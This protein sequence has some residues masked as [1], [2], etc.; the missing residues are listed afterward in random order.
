MASG[1]FTRALA[2]GWER[3]VAD[4]LLR[5]DIAACVDGDPE[6]RL[7]GP[8]AL[9]ERLR[10]LPERRGRV[11]GRARRKKFVRGAIA[12]AALRQ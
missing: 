7:A 11:E 10:S 5:E 8:A 9:A 1:D 12:A 4:P 3:H 2:P 6:N